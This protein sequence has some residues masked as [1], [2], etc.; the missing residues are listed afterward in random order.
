[1]NK[2]KMHAQY[3]KYMATPCLIFCTRGKDFSHINHKILI[4]FFNYSKI[5]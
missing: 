1:M 4:K 3:L 2:A 5:E